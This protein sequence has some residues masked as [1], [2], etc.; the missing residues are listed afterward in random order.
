MSRRTLA[1]D[2]LPL[3]D[4]RQIRVPKDTT[5]M[6]CAYSVQRREKYWRDPESF[7]PERFSYDEIQKRPK[8]SWFPF[9]GGPRLCLG[10]RFAEV[11]SMVALAMVYQRYQLDLIPGQQVR[12]EPIITLRPRTGRCC[13]G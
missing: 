8:F 13:S 7:T 9:G 5:V 3:E 6:L 11:E 10:F 2:I 12:P 4:G 1:D